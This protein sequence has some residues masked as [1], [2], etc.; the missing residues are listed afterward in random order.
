MAGRSISPRFAAYC[1]PRPLAAKIGA[2]IVGHLR[3]GARRNVL[4]RNVLVARV[5]HLERSSR[6]PVRMPGESRQIIS[7]IVV[8]EIIQQQKGIEVAGFSEA[9][10]ALELHAGSVHCRR[11]GMISLTGRSDIVAPRGLKLVLSATCPPRTEPSQRVKQSEEL[12]FLDRTALA[13]P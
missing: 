7:R 11:G 8:P 1:K 4:V 2:V 5:S 13:L 6:S 12:L 10:S 9:R 3:D